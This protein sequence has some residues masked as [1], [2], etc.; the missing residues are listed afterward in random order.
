MSLKWCKDCQSD[1]PVAKFYKDVRNKDGLMSSCRSCHLQKVKRNRR[2]NRKQKK[3]YQANYRA[4]LRVFIDDLKED[5][6][7][8]D[9]GVVYHPRV[10]DFDH[11]PEFDKRYT[12]SKMVQMQCKI[13]TILEEIAKCELVCANCHRIRTYVTRVL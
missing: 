7:C 3:E 10:M 2:K 6:P 5:T 12:I 1:K 8:A 11:L 4:R 9:C 13:E